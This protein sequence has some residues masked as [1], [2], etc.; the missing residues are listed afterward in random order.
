MQYGDDV[1]ND[2]LTAFVTRCGAT[3]Y[4]KVYTGVAPLKS[5]PY[6]GTPLVNSPLPNPIAGAPTGG[7]LVLNPVL[8]TFGLAA[9]IPGYAR[10]TD[11][12]TDDG[13]HTKA[14][15]TAG[16]GSGEISFSD[17]VY[18]NGPIQVSGISIQEGNP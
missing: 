9:G 16:I 5:A 13:T 6:T 11:S 4:L 2:R 18:Q 3:A 12:N 14:Q 1:R 7:L 8:S 15:F 17:Q 10:I